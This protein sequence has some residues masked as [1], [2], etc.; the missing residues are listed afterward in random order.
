M[1][2]F[3]QS[4]NEQ[5]GIIFIILAFIVLP[6]IYTY[7]KKCDPMKNYMRVPDEWINKETHK[8]EIIK[9]P[10]CGGEYIKGEN[11]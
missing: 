9:C 1:V 11:G 10:Y 7:K 2:G 3:S 5:Y 8:P 6:T 4:Q